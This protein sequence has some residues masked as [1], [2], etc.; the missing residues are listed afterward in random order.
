MRSIISYRAT[1]ENRGEVISA[2]SGDEIPSPLMDL[3]GYV[4][5]LRV[6][7]QTAPNGADTLI[8]AFSHQGIRDTLVQIRA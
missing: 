8:L 3:Q 4:W 1:Q 7:G 2:K 6:V 5:G